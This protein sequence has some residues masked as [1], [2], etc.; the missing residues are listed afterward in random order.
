L[1]VLAINRQN[2][3]FLWPIRL[4]GPNGKIDNW[5]RS[6]LEASNKA[7]E[8]WVRISANTTLGAYE[9]AVANASLGEPDWPD[10]PFQDIL[11]IAFRD[12]MI[13]SLDHIVLQRLRGEV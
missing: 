10:L 1:L 6:A 9:I 4:P 13:D 7:R 12:R 11:R 8:R 3:P 5:S 2:V